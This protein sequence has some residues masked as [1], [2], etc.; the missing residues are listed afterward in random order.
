M[1]IWAFTARAMVHE[2]KHQSILKLMSNV[3]KGRG[4]D[5]SRHG[6][7]QWDWGKRKRK[8]RGNR[9]GG[10]GG[11]ASA[12]TSA[13][14]SGPRMDPAKAARMRRQ[15]ATM[16][17]LARDKGATEAERS[18]AAERARRFRTELGD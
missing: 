1:R 3:G 17:L 5:Y 10:G 8:P 6:R 4:F 11:G 15:L 9:R 2:A 18:L 16:D 12:G 13:P 7:A 14:R